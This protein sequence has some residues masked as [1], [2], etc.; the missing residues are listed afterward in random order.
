MNNP[1]IVGG[2]QVNTENPQIVQPYGFQPYGNYNDGTIIGTFNKTA[3]KYLP[4]NNKYDDGTIIEATIIEAFN[5]TDPN[6][7]LNRKNVD[8]YIFDE[9]TYAE[10]QVVIK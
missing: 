5:K 10:L 6:Y 1:Q 8:E 9:N 3:H 4:Q 7:L 2:G